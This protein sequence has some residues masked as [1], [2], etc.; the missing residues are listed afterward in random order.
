MHEMRASRVRSTLM[1][2]KLTIDIVSRLTGQEE[3][4]INFF[5]FFNFF[6]C[7]ENL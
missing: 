5:N 3:E 7:S 2:D 1:N 4:I 6:Y